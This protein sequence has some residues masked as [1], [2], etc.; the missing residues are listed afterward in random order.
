MRSAVADDDEPYAGFVSRAVAFVVDA[1]VIATLGMVGILLASATMEALFPTRRG[2]EVGSVDL[3]LV[4]WAT[5]LVYRVFFWAAVGSTP[6]MW[7]L[8][9][10]VSRLGGERVGVTRA[11][12]RFLAYGV[13]ALVFGLG[14]LWVVVD[15]RH[16]AWHDKVAGTV[17]RYS[18]RRRVGR[19]V[20]RGHGR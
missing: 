3:A 20:G 11:V 17:V 10:R 5:A 19:A 4:V 2:V 7:L 8:G 16:Q 9:L 18:D 15:P 1:F 12:V 6:A 14:Y 13:S